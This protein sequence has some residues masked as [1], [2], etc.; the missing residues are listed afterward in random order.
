MPAT[1]VPR[2][3]FLATMRSVQPEVTR[4]L[5]KIVAIAAALSTP[6]WDAGYAA[7]GQAEFGLKQWND[8]IEPL[9]QARK[10]TKYDDDVN[11]DLGTAEDRLEQARTEIS[12]R[13]PAWP[14]WRPQL[15]FD[16]PPA[17]RDNR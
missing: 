13:P 10:L 16:L 15:S 8:A 11:V 17:I 5:R 2:F 12:A 9:K 7:L 6:K 3:C 1:F 14:A 4:H